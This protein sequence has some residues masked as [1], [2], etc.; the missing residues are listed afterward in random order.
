RLLG[1]ARRLASP[2]GSWRAHKTLLVIQLP[3]LSFLGCVIS[4]G[5]GLAGV[6]FGAS[7]RLGGVPSV[8]RFV[9]VGSS[10]GACQIVVF[11]SCGG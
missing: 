3:W 5:L 4:G 9:E 11:V 1:V 7:R 10:G 8:W 2:A 6:G